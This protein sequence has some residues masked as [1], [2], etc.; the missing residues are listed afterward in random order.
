MKR[1]QILIL[2][3]MVVAALLSFMFFSLSPVFAADLLEGTTVEGTITAVNP[4]GTITVIDE[5][6]NE[7]TL[8]LPE[9]TDPSTIV[10]GTKIEL[11]VQVN[12][13]GTITILSFAIDDRQS[14]HY[15]SQSEDQ[16]P[17]GVKLA[18]QMGIDYATVQSMFCN[19]YLGWG[20]I[21]TV[22]LAGNKFGLDSAELIAARES[23]MGWGQI[24]QEF[25]ITLGKADD[26]TTGKPED[27][28]GNSN[29]PDKPDNP[30][31]PDKPDNPNKPDK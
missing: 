25:G 26:K 21:R 20:E 18:A 9:G 5:A 7:Y 11:E 4:D 13:D 17:A 19:D 3:L 30:N 2:P 14:G 28:G 8:T 31:K 24:K 27:P 1:K 16:H 23:G 10:E 6:G 29:K 22:L 12:E 15:C